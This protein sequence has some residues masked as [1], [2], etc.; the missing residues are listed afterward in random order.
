MAVKSRG[1]VAL[2]MVL[3]LLICLR[4]DALRLTVLPALTAL[5]GAMGIRE[6]H[7]MAR[8]TGAVFSRPVATVFGVGIILAGLATIEDFA[9]YCPVLLA[10]GMIATFLI[11]MNRYGIPGALTGVSAGAFSLLYI[12]LPLALTLQVLQY[13][14]LFLFYGLVLIWTADSGAYFVGRKWG[15]TKMAPNLSP[16]KTIEGLAGGVIACC[17]VA[18]LFKW[19]MPASTFHYPLV[20]VI[21]LGALISVISVL[22]DLAESVL[23]R[24]TGVKDSGR[25]MG[26]HGGVL[27]RI[28]SMLF[29]MPVYYAYLRFMIWPA[30]EQL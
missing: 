16:K 29:C 24:D 7:R 17:L 20:H 2:V 1:R 21:V 13:D 9:Q 18:A 25:G 6:F 3:V 14:R 23:K 5:L 12:A 27:D 28:D 30:V 26:G 10:G 11:Q 4:F 19:L 15:K 8:N 22:G